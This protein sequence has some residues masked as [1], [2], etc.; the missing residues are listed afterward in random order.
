MFC[1]KSIVLHVT[2]FS[3]SQ[4]TKQYAAN[5]QLSTG[6]SNLVVLAFQQ[7]YVHAC[8]Y[9]E[10][11]RRIPLVHNNKGRFQNQNLTYSTHSSDQ[12]FV[13]TKCFSYRPDIILLN[14]NIDATTTSLH[15]NLSAPKILPKS[16]Q[17][18]NL[19]EI[20]LNEPNF[21]S[22]NIFK[23]PISLDPNIFGAESFSTKKLSNLTFFGTKKFLT[24]HYFTQ[25]FVNPIFFS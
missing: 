4:D 12:N 25:I 17:I 21:F 1:N 7:R 18:R 15:P 6:G 13:W 8:G 2:R 22:L 19:S 14:S 23:L 16:V 3:I 24:C 20:I 10:V 11:C 9:Q 5:A